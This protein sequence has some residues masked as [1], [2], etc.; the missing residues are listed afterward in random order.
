MNDLELLEQYRADVPEP[1][2]D[3]L[4]ELR[5]DVIAERRGAGGRAT[6]RR[7][8][9]R[10]RVSWAIAAA[11]VIAVAIV[12]SVVLPVGGPVGPDPA[13]ADV[14]HRFS[15]IAANAPA[16]EP[17]KP[18][19]YVYWETRAVTTFLFF[20]GPGLETFAYRVP[21]TER[22]WV[23]LDG[24]GRVISTWGQ[25]TFLSEADRLAYEAFLG[26][27]AS[28]SWGEFE[29]GQRYED[30]YG[31]GELGQPVLDPGTYPTDAEA[32]RARLEQ[33]E[34][35]GGSNGDWGVFTWAVDIL[36]VSY[37]S[38]E[39]RAAFYEVMS[40]IP[41]TELIG[42]V[43]DPLGRPGVAIGYTRDG[44]RDEVIFD[45]RTGDVLAM[46]TERVED[47]PDAASDVGQ[48]GCCGEFAWAGTE[49]G[50]LMYSSVYLSEAVVVDSMRQRPSE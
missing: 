30:R 33:E 28:E 16:E 34:A 41:G 17:P 37:M 15:K 50:T 6:R 18:G 26:S 3:W 31:P 8:P 7:A 23:G 27:P 19:Q 45:R 49:A 35:E 44:I 11:A 25:P 2:E 46:R 39:L 43:E 5:A 1:D 38:P 36:A 42:R 13:V 9:A 10:R 12:G 20:P 48:T 40:A 4:Q 29:W 22:R 47:N 32:L 21:M 24:S 14:L